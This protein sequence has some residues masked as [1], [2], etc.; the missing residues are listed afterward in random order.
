M[1]NAGAAP[2]PRVKRSQ[3]MDKKMRNV[4]L[5]KYA[6]RDTSRSAGSLKSDIMTL[7]VMEA[8]NTQM[9]PTDSKNR[10]KRPISLSFGESRWMASSF[11]GS[12][13]ISL[14]PRVC[15][16][17]SFTDWHLAWSFAERLSTCW[18]ADWQLACS[19]GKRLLAWSATGDATRTPYLPFSLYDSRFLPGLEPSGFTQ[20]PVTVYSQI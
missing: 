13:L 11:C 14:L 1:A 12:P 8:P 4:D 7:N 16:T 20:R 15:L 5:S 17:S 3:L 19:F 18:F 2:S 9:P 6:L 10:L